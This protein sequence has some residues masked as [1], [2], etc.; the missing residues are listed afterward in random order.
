MKWKRQTSLNP[1]TPIIF[2]NHPQNCDKESKSFKQVQLLNNYQNSKVVQVDRTYQTVPI[3][4]VIYN[5]R[6]TRS[7][8]IR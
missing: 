5:D 3:I 2:I 4:C 1:L 8:K 7:T 6:I